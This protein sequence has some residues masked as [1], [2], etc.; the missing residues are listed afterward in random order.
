MS[1]S[2]KATL[3]APSSEP[4]TL[5]ALVLAVVD[6]V[7]RALE[8]R[9]LDGG[10]QGRTGRAAGAEAGP[11]RPA[12]SGVSSVPTPVPPAPAGHDV[13][14]R[15]DQDVAGIDPVGVRDVA[16]PVPDLRPEVGVAEEPAGDVPEGVA[17]DHDVIGGAVRDGLR[18][19]VP[20]PVRREGGRALQ[21]AAFDGGAAGQP[22]RPRPPA[23][24]SGRYRRVCPGL[25]R[26]GPGTVRPHRTGFPYPCSQPTSWTAL[27]GPDR[28]Q[29]SQRASHLYRQRRPWECPT[30]TR[31]LGDASRK[32]DGRQEFFCRF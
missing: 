14:V 20:G 30:V 13:H 17:L 11:R 5:Q 24:A 32:R 21:E 26:R 8:G 9:L 1:R 31:N 19:L 12:A 22:G 3:V 2:A 10:D 25:G 7:G 27:D 18:A 28:P 16:V 29:N 15:D 6:D 4:M 23:G